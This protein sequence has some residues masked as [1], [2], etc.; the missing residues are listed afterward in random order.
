MYCEELGRGALRC[1]PSTAN[2]VAPSRAGAT[3]RLPDCLAI[4]GH[5]S[6]LHTHTP[7][8][9]SSSSSRDK[10]EGSENLWSHSLTHNK[11]VTAVTL[12]AG[13]QERPPAAPRFSRPS[14][15]RS[16]AAAIS[17]FHIWTWHPPRTL[18]II[19]AVSLASSDLS[20]FLDCHFG[21]H[22]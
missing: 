8:V 20:T 1:C 15:Q 19:L 16:R 21:P 11:Q 17:N 10:A 12:V 5:P 7:S 6:L 4:N 22:T 9:P 13:P 18:L 2:R 14:P 3:S